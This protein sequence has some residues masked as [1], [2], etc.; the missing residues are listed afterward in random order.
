MALQNYQKE[1]TTSFTSGVYPTL[2]LFNYR[3]DAVQQIIYSSKGDKNTG[4]DKIKA[5]AKEKHIPIAQNDKLVDQLAGTENAYV[6][7]VFTKYES[8]IKAKENHLVLVGPRDMGN[9]GTIIRAMAAFDFINLAI[10]K[11]AADIFNPKAIRAS[12]G[13]LF[14]INFE[15]FDTFT[16]YQ[17]HYQNTLYPFMTNG[18]KNFESVT[19]TPPYSLI[20]GSES[21]GLDNS[22]LNLGTSLKI[23]QSSKVDSLNLAAAVGIVLHHLFS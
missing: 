7:G 8:L 12:M 2:E 13:E 19:L 4:L 18:Q 21:A 5:L 15:Y 6:I 20:F 1:D 9:L 16:D 10:I 11:P 17:K 23:K 22:Y 3:G 14:Q